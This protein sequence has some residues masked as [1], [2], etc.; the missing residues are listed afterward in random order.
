ML[1]KMIRFDNITNQGK[2][3]FDLIADDGFTATI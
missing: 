2:D 1:I 3:K